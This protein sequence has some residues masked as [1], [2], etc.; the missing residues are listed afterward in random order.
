[1]INILIV[2]DDK[3]QL[4]ALQASLQKAGYSVAVATDGLSAWDTLNRE[5]FQLVICDINMPFGVSGFSLAKSVK[6]S[7][8]LNT[9]PFIF[10]SG[11][12][13]KE[14]IQKA[15]ELGAEDYLIK[16]IDY[17]ILLAKVES[18]TNAKSKK[19]DFV[20]TKTTFYASLNLEFTIIGISELGLTFSSNIPLPLNKK[21]YIESEIYEE[22]HIPRPLLRV[23]IC[24]PPKDP[25]DKY[26]IKATF[27]GLTEIEHQRIRRWAIENR[28]NG[29][30]KAL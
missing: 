12:R 26:T 24:T 19:Y 25:N 9:I 28:S 2:D 15:I 20:E 6:D 4:Q 29:Q 5:L 1:M 10:I 30:R 23:A 16:P 14:D 21:L 13:E 22:I 8:K 11:R 27:V 18:I 7:E 3:V 17:S